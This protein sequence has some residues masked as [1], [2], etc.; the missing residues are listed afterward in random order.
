VG[1]E[2]QI[3]PGPPT[4]LSL[5]GV[6]QL[7]EHLLCKQGVVG[8][9]PITSTTVLV[10]IEVLSWLEGVAEKRKKPALMV[11]RL[12]FRMELR[13][14]WRLRLEALIFVRVNQVLVRLWARCG[15]KSDRMVGV[16]RGGLVRGCW[17]RDWRP[18]VAALCS[19]ATVV[20]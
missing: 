17:V 15:S 19:E 6:A 9:S 20:C 14:R 5:G 16:L 10:W 13:C 3:L 11:L 4:L 2:V 8:S 1:S 18:A 12:K 7:G